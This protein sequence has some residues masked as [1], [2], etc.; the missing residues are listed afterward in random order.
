MPSIRAQ[1]PELGKLGS[2]IDQ[3]LIKR[4]E[5]RLG[6]A[7]E[8][9]SELEALVPARLGPS[10]DEAQNPYPGLSAYQESD[11]SRFFGRSRAIMEV[12]SRLGEQPLLA[13]VGPPGRASRRSCA[14]G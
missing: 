6:S 14:P 12:V 9:L 11:A 2:V 8:L 10:A 1:S 5:D 7:L 13:V 4:R 3:C